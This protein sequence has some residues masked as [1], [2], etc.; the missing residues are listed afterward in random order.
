M[1]PRSEIH[2]INTIPVITPRQMN[3]PVLNKHAGTIGASI[4]PQ[5]P[6]IVH[7]SAGIFNQQHMDMPLDT[8]GVRIMPPNIRRPHA[9]LDNRSSHSTGQIYPPSA[10]SQ[11]VAYRENRKDT[12]T[13]YSPSMVVGAGINPQLTSG[14]STAYPGM[15]QYPSAMSKQPKMATRMVRT[16]KYNT[17]SLMIIIQS[18]FIVN[19]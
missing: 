2:R 13:L 11:Q 10:L 1:G 5:L 19:L 7:D 9:Q 14:M 4:N 8:S 12:M 17:F 6:G 15:I 3:P 18:S 16:T